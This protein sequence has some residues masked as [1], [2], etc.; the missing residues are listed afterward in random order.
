V[1]VLVGN[2]TRADIRFESTLPRQEKE[3]AF[4]EANRHRRAS[5][6]ELILSPMVESTLQRKYVSLPLYTQYLPYKKKIPEFD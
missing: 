6:L 3:G 1:G 4:R 2:Q 5:S